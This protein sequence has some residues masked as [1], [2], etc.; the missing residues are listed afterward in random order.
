MK[1]RNYMP[2]S[3]MSTL[4]PPKK[5]YMPSMNDKFLFQANSTMRKVIW[6]VTT[7]DL[8][9]SH[10]SPISQVGRERRIVSLYEQA[11][12]LTLHLI[13]GE[14][15]TSKLGPISS[16]LSENERFLAFVLQKIS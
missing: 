12:T 2:F 11:C 7:Y 1:L 3:H 10:C 9:N 5:A 14:N 6:M 13:L 8:D 15:E 4:L 16:S